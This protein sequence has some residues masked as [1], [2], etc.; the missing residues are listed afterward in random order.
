MPPISPRFLPIAL[1]AGLLAILPALAAV[2]AGAQPSTLTGRGPEVTASYDVEVELDAGEHTLDGRETIRWTNRSRVP[3]DDLCFHLYLNGFRNSASSWLRG[4]REQVATLAPDGWGWTDLVRLEADGVDVLDGL[5]FEAPDDGNTEDRTVARVPLPRPVAPGETIEVRAG[6]VAQLPRVVARTGYRRD[7]HLVAQWFPKLAVLE[8]DGTWNCH[9]FHRSSEFF[10]DYGDY[11]VTLSVP[12]GYVVGATGRRV[13]QHESGGTA[14]YRY[15]QQGVHDFAWTAWPGFVERTGTFRHSGLPEVEVRLLLRRETARFAARYRAALEH[16]LRLFGT[17]YGPY[18]YATLTMVDPPWG[19]GEA[20]GMEYPTFIT[21]GTRVLSPLGTQDPEGV[22]VHEFGH[23]FFYGLLASDEMQE[24]WLDEGINTYASARVMQRAYG[25]E[26]WAFRA[27]GVPLVFPGIPRQ[28]P[29]DTSARYFRRPD[30]DPVVR[31]TWGYLDHGSFRFMTYSK[32]ALALAQLERIVG[33]EA[34][35]R[36]MRRYAT[37]WRFRH[38]RTGDFVSSL[39]RSL[40]RDLAPYFA[41][42]LGSAEVL[43]YAVDSVATKRRRGPVGVF[44]DGEGRDVVR[45]GGKLEG[46][47]STVVVRR[48]GGVRLPVVTELVFADGQRARVRWD[49]EERWVRF[50]VTGPELA[51][52]EVDPER[53]L[54]LDVDRLNNSLRVEPDRAA[55][56]RWGQRLRFWVQNVLETFALLA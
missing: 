51:W 33:R 21:T 17:W 56:R 8:D 18:P 4:A 26:A 36:A 24:P 47:E 50:R 23:Q 25:P 1:S 42:T 16:S 2:P 3:V 6:W 14:T 38:P 28:H 31:T 53:V 11:D 7:F 5:A 40:D 34:M 39:S 43:D 27:W 13:S 44:G 19:A 29:L 15:V 41:R 55:S 10:A 22:T 45:D 48:L 12:E 49:G 37:E 9:Q 20:G 54:L 35:E 32:T 52:A 46:W 30:T